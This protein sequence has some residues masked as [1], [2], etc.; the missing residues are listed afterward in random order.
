M[1]HKVVGAPAGGLVIDCTIA[2]ANAARDSM[3]GEGL[4]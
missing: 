1:T 3:G 2:S 4:S